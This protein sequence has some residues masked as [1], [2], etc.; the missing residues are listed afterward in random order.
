[1]AEVVE[2]AGATDSSEADPE[3]AVT[4]VG[5]SPVAE[6]DRPIW[7]STAP[8]GTIVQVRVGPELEATSAIAPLPAAGTT[9]LAQ[10]VGMLTT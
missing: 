2:T 9:M 4:T 3:P 6:T 1:V 8:F 7:R 5:V 10:A